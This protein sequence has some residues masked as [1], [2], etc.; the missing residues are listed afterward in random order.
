MEINCRNL[1]DPTGGSVDFN[2]RVGEEARYSCNPGLVLVG[3]ET[4]LC[5]ANGK[6]SGEEP[7]CSSQCP[8]LR[9]PPNGTVIQSG[10]FPGDTACYVC[11][12]G[13]EPTTMCRTCL[14]SGE[15]SGREIIC[16]SKWNDAHARFGGKSKRVG[17]SDFSTVHHYFWSLISQ[18][19]NQ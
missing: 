13:F 6:W 2:P 9:D 17:F 8:D 14:S 19:V 7:R 11:I 18:F 15:W 3:E 1:T 16:E 4:R 12:E 10:N 5:Q